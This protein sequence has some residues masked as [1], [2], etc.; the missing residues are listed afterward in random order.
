MLVR[1]STGIACRKH[2][3]GGCPLSARGSAERPRVFEVIVR[4]VVQKAV[5]DKPKEMVGLNG[6]NG[7]YKMDDGWENLHSSAGERD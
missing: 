5:E 4:V 1:I 2:G 7:R 3:F 6:Y